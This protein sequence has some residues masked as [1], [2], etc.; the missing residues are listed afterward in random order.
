MRFL[1]KKGLRLALWLAVL[2]ACLTALAPL[3]S[4]IFSGLPALFTANE[5]AWRLIREAAVTTFFVSFSALVLALGLGASCGWLMS[6]TQFRAQRLAHLA[7]LAPLAMP[8]YLLAYAYSDAW[9]YGGAFASAAQGIGLARLD[10]QTPWGLACVLAFSLFPYAYLLLRDAFAAQ[11]ARYSQ[12]AA[13]LGA[14][15]GR[16]FWRINLPLSKSALGIAAC[17]MLMEMLADY[18]AA[19]LLGVQTLTVL[20]MKSWLAA[21]NKPLAIGIALLAT[22]LCASL[23]LLEIHWRKRGANT[24]GAAFTAK[25]LSAKKALIAWVFIAAIFALSFALPVLALL[26]RLTAEGT[27]LDW[28]GLLALLGNTALLASAA[29]LGIV[30]L[31]LL[32]ALPE[33]FATQ[34]RQKVFH[35]F[36]AGLRLGYALPG[37]VLAL[38][39]LT[40]IAW[41]QAFGFSAALTGSLA[42]LIWVYALRFFA[43]GHSALGAGLARITPA[44]QH[45]AQ[46][47]GTTKT[48]QWRQLWLPLLKPSLVSSFVLV[49]I[50]CVK[51]LPATLVLRPFNFDTLAV[52]AYQFAQ[53]ERPAQA[54]LP[55]LCIVI[56]GLLPVIYL[57]R[58]KP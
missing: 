40:L 52:A 46:S 5:I 55:A 28:R 43:V 18:G 58:K 4:L 14:G 9:Q 56:V 15:R 39:V 49:W 42:L 37:S 21:G 41:L 17:L 12:A 19:Q 35:L 48:Q 30:V 51:E 6:Q 25:K 16:Q 10:V 47:L 33:R 34:R 38:A 53:D 13:S 44:M 22:S 31:A 27:L 2:L 50:D 11:A 29:S 23:V 20:L 8:A 36:T 57:F 1:F 32:L 3:A 24:S 45:A 7:L 26:L 54:A